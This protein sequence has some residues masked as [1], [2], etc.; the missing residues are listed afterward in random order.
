[1]KEEELQARLAKLDAQSLAMRKQAIRSLELHLTDTSIDAQKKIMRMRR[2]PDNLPLLYRVIRSM[3]A[4]SVDVFYH[5]TEVSGQEY[6]PPPGN[7]TILCPNHGNSLTDAVVCVSQTPRAVRL[8]AKDT[9]FKV[10][11][12]GWFVRGTQTIPFQ[13]KDEHDGKA[14]NKTAVSIV[15]KELLGGTMVCLFPEGRSRFHWRVDAIQAGVA[16]IAHDALTTATREG[17]MDYQISLL[18]C[19]LNYLHRE[20]FRSGLVVEF[21]PPVVL[22][23]RSDCMK[24]DRREAITKISA[25]IQDLMTAMSFHAEDWNTLRIAHTARNIFAPLGTQMTM[26]EFVRYT[27]YWCSALAMNDPADPTLSDDLTA[28]QDALDKLGLVDHRMRQP[29]GPLPLVLMRILVRVMQLIVLI[30]FIAPGMLL[31]APTF[32]LSRKAEKVVMKRKKKPTHRDEVAQYKLAAGWVTLPPA[33]TLAVLTLA[34]LRG[35]WLEVLWLGPAVVIYL[36][37][38]IRM[39]EEVFAALRSARTLFLLL[40]VIDQKELAN[41]R[42]VREGLFTRVAERAELAGGIQPPEPT[43]FRGWWFEIG[44]KLNPLRRRKKD[45]NEVLR[46]YSLLPVDYKA[47]QKT[48]PVTDIPHEIHPLAAEIEGKMGK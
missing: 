40:F 6:V 22:T 4:I 1:M 42:K 48:V 5:H 17:N 14:D 8:T 30:P 32:F 11:F 2:T 38:A 36:W 34:W 41:I 7:A 29:P 3:F 15:Q 20:K 37:V 16:T 24:L 23:P 21:G 25:E 19:G 47:L 31:W 27:K 18:P 44:L 28:Y 35:S 39:L 9:L 12:F 13:R 43:A 10:P 45:W 26:V 33:L 46:M